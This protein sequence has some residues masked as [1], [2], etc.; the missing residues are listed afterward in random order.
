MNLPRL[1]DMIAIPL[2]AL[3]VWYF[4]SKPSWTQTETVLGLFAVGGFVADVYFVTNS[5]PRLA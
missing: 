5:P 2:F 4:W 3:M 1:G